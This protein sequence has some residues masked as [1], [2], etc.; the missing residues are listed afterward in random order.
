MR[1]SVQSGFCISA[2]TAIF[3]LIR[4]PVVPNFTANLRFALPEQSYKHFQ[5]HHQQQSQFNVDYGGL[6]L[7]CLG[8]RV[9]R[10][11]NWPGFG[12]NLPGLQFDGFA[13][14]FLCRSLGGVDSGCAFDRPKARQERKARDLKSQ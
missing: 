12:S 7:D 11:R 10:S 13:I 3:A 1:S 14:P 9:G 5:G 2:R 8:Q 6:R 4:K